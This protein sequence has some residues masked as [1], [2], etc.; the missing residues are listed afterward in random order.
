MAITGFDEGSFGGW[1]CSVSWL[2]QSQCLG[3]DTVITYIYKMLALGKMG[4]DCR[5]PLGTISSFFNFEFI[6]YKR[7]QITFIFFKEREKAFFFLNFTFLLAPGLGCIM[8]D[9]VPWAGIKPRPP[10][11]G[12]QSLSYWTTREVCRVAVKT[13]HLITS[14]SFPLHR[15]LT[16]G[17]E[18]FT[19]LP[20]HYQSLQP[21]LQS[22]VREKQVS[23]INTYAWNPEKMVEM[24]CKVEIETNV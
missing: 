16:G 21:V 18:F 6:S 10:A 3:P 13:R 12:A 15:H 8:W 24:I 2:Y 17:L 9:L 4:E 20:G 23:Y 14:H 11:L 1:K 19:N 5:G 22:E 7:C